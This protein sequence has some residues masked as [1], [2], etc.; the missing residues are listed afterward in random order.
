VSFWGFG[1]IDGSWTTTPNKIFL[2][3]DLISDEEAMTL[4]GDR[5]LT[6]VD[7]NTGPDRRKFFVYLNQRGTWANVATGYEQ[8]T[9]GDRFTP[10]C[11]IRNLSAK[12]PPVL[13]V[14]GTADIDVP[15]EKS[16]EMAAAL[17]TLGRPYRLITLEK[18][19]HGGRG[20]DP[21]QVIQA[22]QDTMEFIGTQLSEE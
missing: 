22:M 12:Y 4:A 21:K 3:R 7:Q 6:N 20:G 8:K 1:D 15:Y 17:K 5:V 14:H 16:V 11:P 9:E 2:K 13:L 18:G 10:F 19:R